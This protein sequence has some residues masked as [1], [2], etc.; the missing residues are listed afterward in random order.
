MLNKCLYLRLRSRKG[1]KYQFCIKEG[2]KGQIN[3]EKCYICPFKEYKKQ[4]PIKKVSKHKIKVSHETYTKVIERDNYTCQMYNLMDC[5]GNLELHHILYRSQR[6][7]LIDEPT[8][9]IMLCKK[10][11]K[12]VHS[13][14]KK[15]QPML[16]E[17]MKEKEN[18]DET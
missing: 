16:L 18:K 9:C 12:L 1:I 4:K 11:H 15:Y 13:N 6:K 10:H 7:D 3:A 5:E 2:C 17:L 8:N 14:K